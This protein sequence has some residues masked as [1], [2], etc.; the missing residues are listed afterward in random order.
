MP[1][2]EFGVERTTVGLQ[3]DLDILYPRLFKR[4]SSERVSLNKNRGEVSPEFLNALGWFG[5]AKSDTITGKVNTG[6]T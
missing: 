6:R 5:R 3:Q 4:P 1:Q 2:I